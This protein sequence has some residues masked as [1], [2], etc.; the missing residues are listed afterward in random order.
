LLIIT[1]SEVF[2]VFHRDNIF[3]KI[4]TI[5]L[6]RAGHE[7]IRKHGALSPASARAIG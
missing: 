4:L 5:E 7:S 2:V 6:C 3:L 1:G